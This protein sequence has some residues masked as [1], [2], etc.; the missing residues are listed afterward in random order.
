MTCQ[1]YLEYHLPRVKEAI[2]LTKDGWREH[3]FAFSEEQSSDIVLGDCNDVP[4]PVIKNGIGS[5]HSHTIDY[6][7]PSEDDFQI[8]KQSS[9]KYMC[10]ATPKDDIWDI[11]CFDRDLSVCGQIELSG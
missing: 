9:D 6:S 5:F 1:Q 11:R 2:N 8:F 7:K 4:K 3:S 10:Y